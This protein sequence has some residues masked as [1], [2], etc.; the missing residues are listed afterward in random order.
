[1]V[2]GFSLE[3]HLGLPYRD[4]RQHRETAAIDRRYV[5][6]KPKDT[7]TSIRVKTTKPSTTFKHRSMSG[8]GSSRTSAL[9]DD[10]REPNHH[11]MSPSARSREP[12]LTPDHLESWRFSPM[13]CANHLYSFDTLRSNRNIN[14]GWSWI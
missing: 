10:R 3:Y 5:Y 7:P 13:D 4:H 12:I 14:Q 6:I 11:P 1:M 9:F 8:V 2:Q